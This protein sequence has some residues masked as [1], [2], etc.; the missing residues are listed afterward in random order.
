MPNWASNSVEVEGSVED[1][2]A[3]LKRGKKGDREFSFAEFLPVPEYLN[4]ATADPA[5]H[6]EEFAA[7]L[8][9]DRSYDYT[10]SYNWRLAWWGTKW[11]LDESLNIDRS[12]V[13][14]G[15]ISFFYLS[16]WSPATQFWIGL[17]ELYP[18]I[19]IVEKYYETGNDFI[20]ESIIQDGI[21]DEYCT[22]I[23]PEMYERAG[24]A[25]D[26]D[27]FV[28]WDETEEFE[29]FDAWPIRPAS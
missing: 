12:R 6:M 21:L 24:A 7:S 23:E 10:D 2:K 17:S 20:G 18:N 5:T 13:E 26:E 29:L 8:H 11:D 16:A 15:V 9:K 28:D 27:G 3:I 14:D 22:S 25:L 4:G 19:K 1:L